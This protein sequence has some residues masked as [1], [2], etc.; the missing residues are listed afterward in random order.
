[1]SRLR[2]TSSRRAA[3][4]LREAAEVAGTTE[5]AATTSHTNILIGRQR[6][7]VMALIREHTDKDSQENLRLKRKC[8]KGK[9][10]IS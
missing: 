4:I 8:S 10:L 7:A 5:R 6:M 1:M 9:K 3:N 2:R